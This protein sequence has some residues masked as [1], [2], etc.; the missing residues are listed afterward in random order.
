M[1]HLECVRRNRILYIEDFMDHKE[2]ISCL[3]ILQLFYC[4]PLNDGIL[5]AIFSM[6]EFSSIT[7]YTPS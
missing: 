1:C 6:V 4:A 2:R 7:L 5:E 3:L